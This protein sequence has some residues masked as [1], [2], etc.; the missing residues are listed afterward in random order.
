MAYHS[1][2]VFSLR[3]LVDIITLQPLRTGQVYVFFIVALSIY[4]FPLVQANF[5]YIDDH[6]RR[7][8]AATNWGQEGRAV[9]NYLINLLSASVS[10][11]D[12]F[13]LS[14]FFA[15]S[16]LAL[17]LMRLAQHW[18]VRPTAVQLLIVLPFWFNPFYLQVLSYH[19]EA[20]TVTTGIGLSILAVVERPKSVWNN[21][22]VPI[23]LLAAA[24]CFYQLIVNVYIGLA[25][26]EILRRR[27]ADRSLRDDMQLTGRYVLILAGALLIYYLTFYQTITVDRGGIQFPDWEL[28]MDR[29]CTLTSL[30][31]LFFTPANAPLFVLMGALSVAGL[32]LHHLEGGRFNA[33]PVSILAF[34]T[35]LLAVGGINLFLA[36]FNTGART[37]LGLS[38]LLCALLWFSW[39]ALS[40]LHHRS[41]LLIVLPLWVFLSF[42]SL[43]GQYLSDKKQTENLMLSLLVA[44][45]IHNPAL[46]KAKEITLV[47]KGN[48]QRYFSTPLCLEKLYPALNYIASTGY[49]LMPE[50]LTQMGI[51]NMGRYWP[52]EPLPSAR[53]MIVENPFYRLTQAGE[54]AFIEFKPRAYTQRC[55]SYTTPPDVSNGVG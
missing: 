19:Y 9:G 50:Q 3:R 36:G 7:I 17:A 25:S 38:P 54:R 16:I 27:L 33:L 49:I 18:F 13:P 35:L 32:F 48:E 20:L 52:E 8:S 22:G 45:I 42:A 53:E 29:V 21:W 47:T 15:I 4:A 46:Y 28:L 31:F 14:L 30:I 41:T 44:D 5:P 12:L 26:V 37:L 40:T 43:L 55:F 24:I 39:R 23:L 11:P 6:W 1:S 51:V 34:V 2:Q 10:T